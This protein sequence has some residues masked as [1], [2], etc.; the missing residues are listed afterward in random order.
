VNWSAIRNLTFVQ[1]GALLA[2]LIVAVMPNFG[3]KY[4]ASPALPAALLALLGGWLL[5]KERAALFAAP[6]ARRLTLVFVL[7]L[8]PVLISIPASY[9]PRYSASVAG[10]LVVYY[11]TGLALVRVLR[12]DA[13]RTW[14][15]KWITI[16]LVFWI[17]DSVIQYLFGV[18]LF[19]VP[20]GGDQ[21]VLGPFQD[22]LRQPLLLA[23]LLP[24][25]LWVLQRRGVLPAMLFLVAAG[26]IAA[27]G[28]V[29]G[30][31]VMLVLVAAGFYLRLPRWRFKLPAMLLALVAVV[32]AIG[33]TPALKE[34]MTRFADIRELNFETVDHL[35]S[36]RARIWETAGHMLAARPLTGVGVGGFEK[37][38][39][40]YATRPDDPYRDG[41]AR[42]HHAHH[43]F[44]AIAAEAGLPGLLGLIAALV[45]GV[46][47]YRRASSAR[48][49]Q[50]W[51]YAFGL[52]VYFF[53]VNT[54]PPLYHGNWLFPLILLLFA[55]T[56]AALDEPAPGARPGG[57]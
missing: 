1:V 20:R 19:G 45:L 16:V 57:L 46:Y 54:Q 27:L 7:L 55:A 47:W 8:V 18:D 17:A 44:V 56:L 13:E 40:E 34:R 11:F 6:A 33:L 48:R 9:R 26:F 2:L 10:M 49:D 5:W 15:A 39:P 53:P 38:Y 28:A 35:L 4:G 23:L 43:V 25:G 14:L 37:A 36:Y 32:I 51:P 31:L 30:V 24:V 50:A 3:L 21:R 12:G 41:T 52:V 22:S 29:R 42:V